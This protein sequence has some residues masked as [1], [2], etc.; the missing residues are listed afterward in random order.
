MEENAWIIQ[1]IDQLS[2]GACLII[3]ILYFYRENIRIRQDIHKEIL[4]CIKSSHEDIKDLTIQVEKNREVFK[5]S[6]TN[7]EKMRTSLIEDIK[8]LKKGMQSA[9]S[10]ISSSCSLL[11]SAIWT[12]SLNGFTH[13]DH[14]TQQMYKKKDGV[15]VKDNFN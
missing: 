9:E 7:S 14:D 15:V 2:T 11:K 8:E 4:E 12:K 1:H 13:Y 6:I 5:E 10:S 3:A